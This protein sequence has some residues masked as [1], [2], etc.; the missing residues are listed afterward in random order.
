[1]ASLLPNIAQLYLT[2]SDGSPLVGGKIYTYEAGTTTP[3]VTYADADATTSNTNPVILDS[4]GEAVI[5]W[6]GNYKVVVKDSLDNTIRTVDDVSTIIDMANITY[7]GVTLSTILSDTLSHV[8]EDIDALKAVD[9]TLYTMAYV[10]GY[11][12]ANDGGGGNYWYDSGDTTTADNGGSVIVASDGA[13][14]KLQMHG[15]PWSVLQFGAKPDYTTDATTAIQAAMDALAGDVGVVTVDG[16]FLIGNI[17]IPSGCTLR[18]NN[19]APAQSPTGTYTPSN[20][21]S[22]F[23]MSSAN[24]ITTG[25][26]GSCIEGILILESD[27]APGATYALPLTAGN[28]SSAVANFAGTAITTPAT[29]L[30]NKIK[31]CVILGFNLCYSSSGYVGL[32]ADSVFFDGTGGFDVT[33]SDT[34]YHSTFRDCRVEPFLTAHLVD[35]TKDQRTGIAFDVTGGRYSFDD[36]QVRE[37]NGFLADNTFVTHNTCAVKNDNTTANGFYGFKYTTGGYNVVNSGCIALNCGA[38]NIHVDFPYIASTYYKNSISIIGA[39]LDNYA[40]PSAANG[41]IYIEEGG[42]NIT[43]CQLGYN[44]TYGYIKLGTTT[45]PYYGSVDNVSVYG[46]KQP[47]F[48]DATAML[49]C[50]VGYIA[51]NAHSGVVIQPLTWTPVLKAGTTV[52]T[53]TSYGHFTIANQHVTAYFDIT[54]TATS[55]TGNITI[56]GLP[57]TA[58]NETNSMLGMGACGYFENLGS[59]SSPPFFSVAKNT[60]IID[61]WQTGASDAARLTDANITS[62]ARLVGWVTY[63][64]VQ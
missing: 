21:A 60:A 39:N 42:Y 44:G 47:I 23:V 18:G 43:G 59:M 24:T 25:A 50:R 11:Y 63:R 58:A 64:I 29:S 36:C 13:R 26:S 37:K 9:S 56:E 61:V 28:A 8:V 35:A 6:Q 57:Y 14:W 49:N 33:A 52:Q 22:C 17:T 20:H 12:A 40:T 16:G 30:D 15:K 31:D 4:R 62:T 19:G 53:S 34:I 27:L 46:T 5:F 54:L 7:D 10:K 51:Y 1:M 2:T 32:I 41:L 38:S 45:E 55:S 3:K 48:G